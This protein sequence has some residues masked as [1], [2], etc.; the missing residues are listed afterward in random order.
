MPNE[1]SSLGNHLDSRRRWNIR[2]R[3]A[4]NSACLY[5]YLLCCDE[6]TGADSLSPSLRR[7]LASANLIESPGSGVRRRT[8]NASRWRDGQMVLRGAAHAYLLAEKNFHK[9]QGYGDF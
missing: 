5:A 4:F 6:C 2:L 3:S 7:C 8:G 9:L 1:R